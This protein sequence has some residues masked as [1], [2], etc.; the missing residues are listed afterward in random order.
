MSRGDAGAVFLAAIGL[1]IIIGGLILGAPIQQ[2]AW[3][4]CN[5]KGGM[6]IAKSMQ[7]ITD[8][9]IENLWG[10]SL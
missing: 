2:K 7:C 6:Y 10:K 3:D 4:Y 5:S 8:D 9:G 1:A